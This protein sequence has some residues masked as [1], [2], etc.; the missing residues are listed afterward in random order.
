[1]KCKCGR[2]LLCFKCKN[3]HLCLRWCSEFN[4]SLDCKKFEEAKKND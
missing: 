2:K 1:M 3:V 4:E